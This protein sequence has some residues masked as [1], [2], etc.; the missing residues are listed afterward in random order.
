[1]ARILK[2]FFATG[3]LLFA[4]GSGTVAA[5]PPSPVGVTVGPQY[6]YTAVSAQTRFRNIAGRPNTVYIPLGG[7]ANPED[8][9][10]ANLLLPFDFTFFGHTYTAGSQLYL[11][12]NGYVL[13]GTASISPVASNLRTE[14]GSF[15]NQPAIAPLFMDLVARG[16]QEGG[17][18]VYAQTV[19]D[20]GSRKLTVEW[21]SVQDFNNGEPSGVV[22]F[23]T[24][25]HEGPNG[26]IDFNYDTTKFGTA[27]DNGAQATIGIR[28]SSLSDPPDNFLQWGF[29]PGSAEGEGYGLSDGGFSIFF[30][31]NFSSVPEPTSLALCGVGALGVV[32]ATWRQ[33]RLKKKAQLARR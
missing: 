8:D 32:V 22:T 20:P 17:P 31:G 3:T 30:N 11:N 12:A 19:G 15:G 2:L 23:Q 6:G 26:Q 21:S 5:D 24:V 28:D 14:G 18:G 7:V 29:K 13:F 9:G 10:Y 4:L 16:M 25:L 1:M 33:R 27:A